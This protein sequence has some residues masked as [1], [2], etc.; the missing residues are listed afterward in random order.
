LID[1]PM[2]KLLLVE[3][4]EGQRTSLTALLGEGEISVVEV[5]TAAGALE[6]V[7]A[8]HFDCV[9]VDLGL[10][11]MPGAD[12]I[13]RIRNLPG[14]ADLPVVVYTGK[15]LAPAEERRLDRI[16][17]TV[18]VKD[19]DSSQ[20]LLDETALFLH[21]TIAGVPPERQIRVDRAPTT[22]RPLVGPH[23]DASLDGRRVL[24]IDDDLR[25]IFSLT[26]ALEQHGLDVLFA[27]SGRDGLEMLRSTPG[28]DAV[29]VDIM[30]PEMDGYETMRR[31]REDPAYAS[32]PLIAVTAKAMVG[33]REKCLESGASDYVSKPVDLD[34]LLAVL[35]VQIQNA[36]ASKSANGAGPRG[37]DLSSEFAS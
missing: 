33:D 26:S 24:L 17:S 31:V 28:I 4:D 11:D 23:S 25:N 6:A 9:I 35:R 21:R 12:L 30:M 27:E 37:R 2:R 16:G 13:E 7:S 1:R 29:L 32:L 14:G 19:V 34:Q 15:D 5:G 22:D 8:G 36:G 10:P 20:R 3:D 18:L